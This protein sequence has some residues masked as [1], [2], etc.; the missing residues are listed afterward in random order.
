MTNDDRAKRAIEAWLEA[1][2]DPPPPA[3]ESVDL[4]M[5]HV[6]HTP[7][8]RPIRFRRL[9][10][11]PERPP[12][13][14]GRTTSMLN[15]VN[16]VAAGLIALVAGAAFLLGPSSEPAVDDA[17]AAEAEITAPVEFTLT[18]GFGGAV[19]AETIERVGDG[20]RRHVGGVWQPR[21]LVEASDPRLRG[22]LYDHWSHDEF[23]DLEPGGVTLTYSMLRIVYG[24]GAWQSIPVH[25]AQPGFERVKWP[26]TLVGE[27]AYAGLFASG[28]VEKTPGGNFRLD[29]YIFEGEPLPELEPYLG[30]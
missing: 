21:I 13:A 29:G 27:G 24:E 28:W 11:R 1:T 6:P 7:Q 10:R 3:D 26:A 19:R 15:P 12:T 30:E 2:S 22:T 23:P 5:G 25:V 17:P 20:H 14:T 8:E 18:Y 4:A 16:A 9:R